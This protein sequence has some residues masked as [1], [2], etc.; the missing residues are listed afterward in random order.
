[1]HNDGRNDIEIG[2]EVLTRVIKKSVMA[3][4]NDH[5][6]V[7]LPATKCSFKILFFPVTDRKR[8]GICCTQ[9][10]NGMP[11][12]L[13]HTAIG[14]SN[15]SIPKNRAYPYLTSIKTRSH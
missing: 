14:R 15:S 13:R 6:K 4:P 10:I 3:G 5:G 1:M 7:P 12:P 11:T 8:S 2:V 9:N